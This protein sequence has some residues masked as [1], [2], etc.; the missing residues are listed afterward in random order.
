M[1]ISFFFLIFL[2]VSSNP[3]VSNKRIRF[4]LFVAECNGNEMNAPISMHDDDAQF[5]VPEKFI[6]LLLLLVE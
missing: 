1:D 3:F 2:L 5:H 4:H 6:Y